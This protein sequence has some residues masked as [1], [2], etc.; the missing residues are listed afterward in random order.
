M[1]NFTPLLL[2]VIRRT[3]SLKREIEALAIVAE[4][5][6]NRVNPRN[7]RLCTELAALLVRLTLGSGSLLNQPKVI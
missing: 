5:S 3:L 2:L 7:L 1:S 4:P 6:V